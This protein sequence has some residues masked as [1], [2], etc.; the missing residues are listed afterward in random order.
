[1]KDRTTYFLAFFGLVGIFA[2]LIMMLIATYI[3]TDG[4][5]RPFP[6]HNWHVPDTVWTDLY[7]CDSTGRL[8]KWDTDE[9]QYKQVEQ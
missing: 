4:N 8:M 1:M 3:H 7:T 5:P 2:I 6:R 9:Q